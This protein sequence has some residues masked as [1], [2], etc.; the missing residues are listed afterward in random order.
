MCMVGKSAAHIAHFLVTSLLRVHSPGGPHH[1]GVFYCLL[2]EC[3]NRAPQA[4][5][6]IIIIVENVLGIIFE[7]TSTIHSA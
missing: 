6:G 7:S 5:S 3:I 4:T 1:E 2:T